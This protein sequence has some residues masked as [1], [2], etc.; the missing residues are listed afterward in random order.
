MRHSKLSHSQ[1]CVYFLSLQSNSNNYKLIQFVSQIIIN[2]NMH[3]YNNKLFE[4]GP[5][6][7]NKIE[8][9]K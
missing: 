3:M 9:Y 7:E 5:R 4:T 2:L 6:W 1:S 8:P